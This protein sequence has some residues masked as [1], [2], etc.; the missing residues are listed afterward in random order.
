MGKVDY[1]L[2][3]TYRSS[4]VQRVQVSLRTRLVDIGLKFDFS[5]LGSA[6]AL[7]KK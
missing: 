3:S 5:V 2:V 6:V 7:I 4:G 1:V